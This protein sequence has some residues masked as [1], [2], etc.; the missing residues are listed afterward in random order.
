MRAGWWAK[1]HHPT[2]T[3]SHKDDGCAAVF[4]IP[5]PLGEGGE[6]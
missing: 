3:L 2:L 5:L 6:F 4:S 1:S